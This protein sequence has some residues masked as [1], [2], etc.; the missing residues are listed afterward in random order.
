MP[1]V[2]EPVSDVGD[3]NHEAEEHWQAKCD[4]HECGTAFPIAAAKAG[5]HH[6]H[7]AA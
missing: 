4:E 5:D 3:E 6:E 1:F 2:Y 7:P